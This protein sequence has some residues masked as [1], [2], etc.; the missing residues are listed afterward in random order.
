MR[1]DDKHPDKHGRAFKL[2]LRHFVFENRLGVSWAYTDGADAILRRIWELAGM[3]VD[4]EDCRE[5]VGLRTL[6]M[7]SE[8]GYRVRIIQCPEPRYVALNYFVALAWNRGRRSLLPWRNTP[9]LVRYLTLE[10]SAQII[11]IDGPSSIL[12][13]WTVNSHIN[14]GNGPEPGEESFVNAI[15][16]ILRNSAA[17]AARAVFPV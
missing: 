2:M 10:S 6:R 14:Y 16:P 9:E 8:A 1:D 11:G 15:E 17:V 7:Y 12:G 13:E 4:E 5:P 3:E